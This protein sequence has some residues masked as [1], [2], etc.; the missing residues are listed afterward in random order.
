MP[1]QFQ[2]MNTWKNITIEEYPDTMP[3]IRHDETMSIHV[4]KFLLRPNNLAE[5]VATMFWFDA[6]SER[7]G[8]LVD[9]VL[10]YVPGARQDRLNPTG[11]Y[12]F[13]LK[14][15]ARML[16]DRSFQSVT[17]LDPHS[18]VAAGL[19][20]RC[21]VVTP[22]DIMTRV[23]DGKYGA[24][25]SPD[26]GAEKRASAVARKLGVPMIHAWKTRNVATGEISGFGIDSFV[27][28]ASSV[29]KPMLIVDDI[30]DGGGTF[31]GLADEIARHTVTGTDLHLYTTHGLYSRG[32][33]ELSKRFSHLYCTDSIIDPEI[34]HSPANVIVL[35]VCETL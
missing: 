23:P 7:G 15:V 22:A 28:A 18:D 9:L 12:L 16:N 2:T 32:T 14:S 19:I 27:S 4:G 26:A 3:L 31:I 8:G 20:D 35:N 29:G 10:P 34:E 25:I 13:T 6:F 24:V 5:F 1:F 11:D 17:I 21:R 33:R 30:C